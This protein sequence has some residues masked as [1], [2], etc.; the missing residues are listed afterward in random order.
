[1]NVL[2]CFFKVAHGFNISN[3]SAWKLF[4]S[5]FCYSFREKQS[6]TVFFKTLSHKLSSWVFVLKIFGKYK[7]FHFIKVTYLQSGTLLEIKLCSKYFAIASSTSTSIYF[8]E[9]LLVAASIHHTKQ[10]T[11][12]FLEEK[13]ILE[14]KI[15]RKNLAGC[16]CLWIL[17]LRC[18]CKNQTQTKTQAKSNK[19]VLM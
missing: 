12:I 2:A 8:V 9:H 13:F 15:K 18:A 10:K 6:L 16:R 3:W 5:L 17:L 14:L 7:E 19:N 4:A 11:Y 1:M